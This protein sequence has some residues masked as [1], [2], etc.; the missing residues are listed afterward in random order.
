M[1]INKEIPVVFQGILGAHSHMS[2]LLFAQKKSFSLVGQP[3][4]GYFDD[5]FQALLDDTGI[6]WLPIENSYAGSITQT[7][8]FLRNAHVQVLAGY[9]HNV[10]HCL[11]AV[12][13]SG[14]DTIK[15][16]FSHPQA[17]AQCKHFLQE[18]HYQAEAYNDT[19]AAARFVRDKQDKK[20]ACLCSHLAADIYDLELLDSSVQDVTGNTTRFLLVADK[21]RIHEFDHLRS[22]NNSKTIIV[23]ETLGG[24]SALHRVLSVFADRK[25]NLTKIT[26]RPTN[27]EA[28]S[29]FFYCEIEGVQSDKNI[30]I[31]LADLDSVTQSW[32]CLGE[33]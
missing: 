32:K 5:V 7:I 9:D 11:A 1:N 12:P 20:I 29:Y 31:A 28:F 21:N 26:S 22:T 25:I 13:G 17:L 23:F 2:L 10:S 8:D 15:K 19:A 33:Y 27:Q 4:E 6:G 24:Y 30:S 14:V 3:Q 18:K 16:V